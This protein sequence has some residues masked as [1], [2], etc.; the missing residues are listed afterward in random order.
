LRGL[1]GESEG[2]A[3]GLIDLAEVCGVPPLRPLLRYPLLV[4]APA[5][6]RV[7]RDLRRYGLGPSRMYP[8]ALPDIPGLERIL[9]GQGRFPAARAFAGRILTL[10]THGRVRS[11][12]IQKMRQVLGALV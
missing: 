7:Y 12:D 10:P 11:G 3:E 9:A 2:P 6:D 1:L 4:D 5:R 8:A